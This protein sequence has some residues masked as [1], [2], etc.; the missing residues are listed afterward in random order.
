MYEVFV[1]KSR[2][3]PGF[4]P[5]ESEGCERLKLSLDTDSE[6]ILQHINILLHSEKP[7][8][9]CL[10]E[11]GQAKAA[12]EILR[13]TLKQERAAGGLVWHKK[14]GLLMIYRMGYWD[15]PKGK[16]LPG[17]K[18]A[19]TAIREV[20]EE[21]GIPAPLCR[22]WFANSYHIFIRKHSVFLKENSWFLMESD[23]EAPLHP[24]YEESIT[25]VQWMQFEDYLKIKGKIYP[26]L[27]SLSD[28]FWKQKNKV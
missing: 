26:S 22:E 25:R 2:V 21:C 28:Q 3:Y 18:P 11:P 14:K 8:I 23:T 1:N 16:A 4:A 5:P 17:E 27:L 10:G 20:Q 15:Y 9:L 24:Q 19:E 7:L 6:N 13:S 12:W